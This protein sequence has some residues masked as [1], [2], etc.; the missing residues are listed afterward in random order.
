[1]PRPFGRKSPNNPSL[2]RLLLLLVVDNVL[3]A[4]VQ[5]YLLAAVAP[6]VQIGTNLPDNATHVLN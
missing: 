5:V 6:W 1:M 2:I 3:L 4:S